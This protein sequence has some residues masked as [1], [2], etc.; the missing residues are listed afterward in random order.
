[1]KRFTVLVTMLFFLCGV[2]SA[3]TISITPDTPNA[4]TVI[5]AAQSGDLVE[6]APGTYT[7][8]VVV[9]K[10]G[11]TIAG[12]DSNNRPVFDYTGLTM[13]TAVGT[14]TGTDWRSGY[15]WI[16]EASDVVVQDIE[17]KGAMV[18][19]KSGSTAG[20]YFGLGGTGTIPSAPG[21]QPSNVVLRRLKVTGCENG[22]KG[23]GQNFLIENCYVGENGIPGKVTGIH[24]FYLLAGKGIIRNCEMG[25]SESGQ[26]VNTRCQDLTIEN[27]DW[28]DT[29]S[30]PLLM[31]TPQYDKDPNNNTTPFYQTLT[32]KDNNISGTRHNGLNL[33]KAFE[34]NNSN[35]YGNLIQTVNMSGNTVTGDA[36][37]LGNLFAI[38]RKSTGGIRILSD[39]TNTYTSF[40]RSVY[41]GTTGDSATVPAGYYTIQIPEDGTVPPPPP[42]PP[43]T[44]TLTVN[45]D[46]VQSQITD[47]FA[48]WDVYLSDSQTSWGTPKKSIVYAD[49]ML[50]KDTIV[51]QIAYDSGKTYYVKLVP[52]NVSGIQGPAATNTVVDASGGGSTVYPIP[53]APDSV[54]ATI[55]QIQ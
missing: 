8:K 43:A 10:P 4:Y 17:I 34:V 36:A 7:F 19:G 28:G 52:K 6:I 18:S 53:V 9:T 30:Y 25:R 35:T 12:A 29:A 50:M 3:A 47:G 14:Y 49:G 39:G 27:C 45:V 48:G 37:G 21:S 16:I 15:P 11:V 44:V 2:A 22:I 20:L 23:T 13:S 24:N 33:S 55:I 1:M 54:S 32:L 38:Y 40:I 31:N 51:W 41:Y 5:E 46:W 26:Q 42:P